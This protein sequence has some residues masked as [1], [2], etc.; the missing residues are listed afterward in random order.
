MST[1]PQSQ[2]QFKIASE[3]WEFEQIHQL[4][5][6]TFVEEIPQHHAS[7]E[8]RLVDKFHAEN[9]YI[10]CLSG[11]RLAGMMCVR[12]KRP[13]SLDQKL[14]NLD[15]YLPPGRT[16]CEIRLLAVEKEFRS[17][18]V[19]QG[20]MATMARYCVEHGLNL[21]LIS[22][23]TRQ[24]KL[25]RHMGFVPF[26][27]LV[28]SGEALYQPMY[29]TQEAFEEHIAEFRTAANHQG[30]PPICLLPGPVGV[31]PEVS[32]AFKQ[33]PESHRSEM[34]EADV[35]ITKRLLR[36][37]TQAAHAQLLLGTGT[38]AN[39]AIA[40]QLSLDGRSGLILANGEFGERLVDH[41]RRFG[42]KFEVVESPWGA[43]FDLAVVQS[44]LHRD[45]VPAWL[46]FVHC[47]T[48]T[49]VLNDLD[50]LKA[51]CA[52]RNVRLCADCISSIGAVPV[53]LRGVSLASC[54][55]SKALGAY[56]GLAIVFHQNDIAPSPRLPRYLDVG[57]YAAGRG[58]PYSHSSNLV[59]ALKAALKAR[60]WPARFAELRETS[61][62]LRAR[63]CEAG[64]DLIGSDAG[65][66]PAVTTWA[67]P[68]EMSAARVGS[69]LERAGFLLSWRS[70]YLRRRNW[71]Q[72]SLMG[73][74][75][76]R[77]LERLV[78]SVQQLC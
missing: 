59:L 26:G 33:A 53:D 76:R 34:F 46:W 77:D 64:C 51:L 68:K 37:L 57:V 18:Y 65:L 70:E 67:L 25:Y 36:G 6:R 54:V 10:I 62:W 5:Y 41:A 24:Q 8:R 58:V 27:P 11:R 31:L 12:A 14:P 19:F 23:T 47:E 48:S 40:A 75:T 16:P 63:L 1:D 29:L 60:D 17:G 42:L 28:G 30:P 21:A 15:S 43:A 52:A 44:R 2:L 73:A 56:P 3:D 49:G 32:R 4:N 7:P 22:G 39:D 55:S 13:F 50:A 66:C 69:E 9:T 78:N 71:I 35:R 45:P 38:L 20:L 61:A 72:I 74:W